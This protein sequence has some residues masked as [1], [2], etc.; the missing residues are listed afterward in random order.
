[1][2]KAYLFD[3][4]RRLEH[5]ADEV[6]VKFQLLLWAA[7][8]SVTAGMKDVPAAPVLFLCAIMSTYLRHSLNIM[9]NSVAA[10]GLDN[11]YAG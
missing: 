7:G 8:S 5:K 10:A 6:Q 1:M 3:F 2:K 9:T 11:S 4:K